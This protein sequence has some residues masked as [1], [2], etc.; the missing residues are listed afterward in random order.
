MSYCYGPRSKGYVDNLSD[1]QKLIPQKYLYFKCL[2]SKKIEFF[3][4]SDDE[5]K[6]YSEKG[7][8][9]QLDLFKQF[10]EKFQYIKSRNFGYIF[11]LK[12][13]AKNFILLNYLFSKKIR[14]DLMTY[15]EDILA[16]F[17]KNISK[18]I[19]QYYFINKS[20]IETPSKID[21]K[22]IFEYKKNKLIYSKQLA[23][24]KQKFETDYKEAIDII[25]KYE[26]DNKFKNYYTKESKKFKIKSFEK[27][28]K[29][30]KKSI[31]FTCKVA[32][33]YKKLFPNY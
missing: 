10:K 31:F 7:L 32:T 18:N 3:S 16:G 21:A 33:K 4:P 14:L 28:I 23:E 6:V 15:F 20:T 22:K 1:I 26:K 24:F 12:K 13:N 29:E 17:P 19:N 30:V 11:I 5:L 8:L 27:E 2:L 9:K 25:K